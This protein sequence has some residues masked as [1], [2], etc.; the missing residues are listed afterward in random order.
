MFQLI[1]LCVFF[2]QVI[3][4]AAPSVEPIEVEFDKRS[5]LP[6]ITFPDAT[7]Q[8]TGYNVFSDVSS[9]FTVFEHV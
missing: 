8:A 5:G 6:Q 4:L 3:V 1:W 2:S 9:P 7:Y